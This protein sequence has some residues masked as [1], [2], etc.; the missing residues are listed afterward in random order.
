M[1]E[2]ELSPLRGEVGVSSA[3]VELLLVQQERDLDALAQQW[4]AMAAAATAP[5]WATLYRHWAQ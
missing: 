4:T 3:A 2:A 1:L 5:A